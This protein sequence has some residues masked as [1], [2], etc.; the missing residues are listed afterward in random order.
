MPAGSS[1]TAKQDVIEASDPYFGW[2]LLSALLAAF[3]WAMARPPIRA[4]TTRPDTTA[5]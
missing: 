3:L 5:G 1:A 4:V 2:L